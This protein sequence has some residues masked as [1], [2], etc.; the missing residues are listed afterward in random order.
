M[1]S[2]DVIAAVRARGSGADDLRD[3]A[4]EAFHAIR[5]RLELPWTRENIH[6]G[7]L[8]KFS[9]VELL[10][11]EV[12]ARAVEMLVCEHF[13]EPYDQDQYMLLACME[14]TRVGIATDFETF[15]RLVNQRACHGTEKH[16]ADKICDLTALRSELVFTKL[17]PKKRKL[18]K[19][20]L[21]RN[22]Q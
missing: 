6:Q 7:I 8:E 12:S 22:K 3:A 20:A 10:S 21:A 5:A 11:E 14:N 18:S 15:R 4:H 13:D 1:D 17:P 9:K 19:R 2:N 16:Y